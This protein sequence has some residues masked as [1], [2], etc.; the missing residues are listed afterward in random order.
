MLPR[1]M[2]MEQV[3][4]RTGAIRGRCRVSIAVFDDIEKYRFASMTLTSV[5]LDRA[6]IAQSSLAFLLD[7]LSHPDAE[8]R[9]VVG[10]GK[11]TER[12]SSLEPA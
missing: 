3:C 7:R 6:W 5:G 1:R 2:V 4:S 11:P 10:P 8:P 12:T 9:Q